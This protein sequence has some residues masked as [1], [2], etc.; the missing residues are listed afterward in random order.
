[1]SKSS[2]F[3]ISILTLSS[4]SRQLADM[5][6]ELS[7][8]TSAYW[9]LVTW[10]LRDT[11]WKCRLPEKLISI[12]LRQP[13]LLLKYHCRVLWNRLKH[14]TI[15]FYLKNYV[16]ESFGWHVEGSTKCLTFCRRH[17]KCIFLEEKNISFWL[18]LKVCSLGVQLA[19][20]LCWFRQQAFIW[21]KILWHHIMSHM[22]QG[23][24]WVSRQFQS[25][26]NL[27]SDEEFII[28]GFW[29][30]LAT[31]LI[32]GTESQMSGPWVGNK[33]KTHISRA[34][35]HLSDGVVAVTSEILHKHG[36]L[37]GLESPQTLISHQVSGR[38]LPFKNLQH[39]G[40]NT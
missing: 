11:K 19:I 29:Y 4:D 3:Y 33:I 17:F 34:N 22:S 27:S 37:A 25:S 10:E 6:M 7:H 23:L 16:K 21:S 38:I 28:K 15:K 2:C 18:K 36:N 39:E 5:L 24:Q 1:M 20:S 13:T 8:G 14:L 9:T 35:N 40:V 31:S 32:E 26:P 30:I 12:H